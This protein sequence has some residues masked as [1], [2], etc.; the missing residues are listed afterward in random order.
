VSSPVSSRLEEARESP[1]LDDSGGRLALPAIFLCGVTL[2]FLG[3]ILPAWRSHL[4]ASFSGV[5]NYFLSL[6]VGFAVASVAAQVVLSGRGGR[7]LLTLAS[8]WGCVGFAGLA[9]ASWAESPGY[10]ARER[11]RDS[12]AR[13]F[14]KVLDRLTGRQGEARRP[15]RSGSPF[16][17]DRAAY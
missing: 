7:F 5:G 10:S 14:S 12:R 8:A 6:A 9:L 3:A 11:V 4:E 17:S 13:R 15:R 1:V 16:C 2:S